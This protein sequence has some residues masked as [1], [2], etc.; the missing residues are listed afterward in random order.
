MTVLSPFRS[1]QRVYFDDL[2]ALNILHNVRYLLFIERARG[3][4]FNALGFHWQDDLEHNPDKWH[5]IAEHGIRYLVPFR[6][7]GEI[8]V[9]LTPSKLGSSSLVIDARVRSPHGDI[10]FADG[11]T[12][13]VRLDPVTNKPCPWSE[14]FRKALHPLVKSPAA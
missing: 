2:D 7:E 13:L 5:V 11:A 14:R 4:L 3:E 9:E 1:V 12:R 8:L 10:V 6:G